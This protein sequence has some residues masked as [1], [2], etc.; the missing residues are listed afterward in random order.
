ML[1]KTR[2]G[3]AAVTHFRSFPFL[4]HKRGIISGSGDQVFHAQRPTR[5]SL[6]FRAFFELVDTMEPAVYSSGQ[7]TRLAAA[8][9]NSSHEN[10]VLFQ[11]VYHCPQ[12]MSSKNDRGHPL[13]LCF[14]SRSW[15][16]KAWTSVL[17]L[18]ASECKEHHL[19]GQWRHTP[20]TKYEG[21][22]D[23]TA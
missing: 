7:G 12:W 5:F 13:K 23:C 1:S 16:T 8:P 6:C 17:A 15:F 22:L 9:N 2:H 18:A 4:R 3:P 10:R 21:M 14:G 20:G 19:F 11:N